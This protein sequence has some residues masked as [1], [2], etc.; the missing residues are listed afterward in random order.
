MAYYKTCYICGCNL[1]PGETCDCEE[2]SRENELSFG[3]LTK[4]RNETK[5]GQIE[6][7]FDVKNIEVA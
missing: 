6:F 2:Q 7:N 3:K 5:T 4:I 1:D